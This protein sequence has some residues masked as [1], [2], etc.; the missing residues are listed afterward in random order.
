MKAVRTATGRA[1]AAARKPTQEAKVRDGKAKQSKAQETKA[2]ET[3]T[4]DMKIRDNFDLGARLRSFRT[5]AGLSQRELAARAGVPNGLIAMVERNNSSPSVASL[6]KILGGLSLTLADFFEEGE[7]RAGGKVFF[8]PGEF[9]DLTS[10]IH[11]AVK[12]VKRGRDQGRDQGRVILRQLGDADAHNLQIL[13]EYYEPGADTGESMLEHKSHEG[14][15]VLS[16]S[17]EVTVG[18]QVK[19][20]QPGDGYLFDSRQRHRFRN[21]G[22]VPCIIVSACTPPYL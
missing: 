17:I 2:R 21:I 19:I 3:K 18:S 15:V 20:L 11:G 13:H 9:L 4:K 16:G 12:D 6:R 14:G 1:K 22:D 5:A 10:H 8:G 7:V